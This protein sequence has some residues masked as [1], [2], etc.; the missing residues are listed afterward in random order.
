LEIVCQIKARIRLHT[1]LVE[2]HKSQ[3]FIEKE[4]SGCNFDTVVLANILCE[5]AIYII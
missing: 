3:P 5:T 4:K 1:K 2:M